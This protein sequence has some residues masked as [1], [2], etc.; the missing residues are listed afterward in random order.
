MVR[1]G[2]KSIAQQG[3]ESATW[4]IVGIL[5]GNRNTEAEEL[6]RPCPRRASVRDVKKAWMGE[7]VQMGRRKKL[8][9][10]RKVVTNVVT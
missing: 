6:K 3:L 8:V 9:K 7:K 2:N 10:G 5:D 1:V 4:I